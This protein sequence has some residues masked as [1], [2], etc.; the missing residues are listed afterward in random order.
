VAEAPPAPAPGPLPPAEPTPEYPEVYLQGHGISLQLQPPFQVAQ[1]PLAGIEQAAVIS[2]WDVHEPGAATS[3]R[4]GLHN[5]VL[6]PGPVPAGQPP[7]EPTTRDDR[8]GTGHGL[9]L[10][11]TGTE[12]RIPAPYTALGGAG[13]LRHGPADAR[14]TIRVGDGPPLEWPD[15]A[16][17]H[18]GDPATGTPVYFDKMPKRPWGPWIE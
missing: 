13:V 11:P 4:T 8:R 1:M 17:A 7:F 14:W 10:G 3:G 2:W 6:A 9:R 16:L 18:S 15:K 12:L 5:L